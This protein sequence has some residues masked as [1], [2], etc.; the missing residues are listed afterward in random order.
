MIEN[1]PLW[2]MRTARLSLRVTFSSIQLPRSGMMRQL[3]K[4]RSPVPSI[5]HD[6]IDART[7]VELVDHDALGAVD[8]ELA[9]AEH[10]GH[11]AQVDL[12]LDRLLLGQPQPDLERP[13]VGQTK[14]A[15][16]VRLVARL[17]QLVADVLQAERLVVAFDR[18]NFAKHAFD[19][20][21]LALLPGHLVLQEGVVAAG[22]DLGQVGDRIGRALRT[23]AANF[24]GLDASLGGCRHRKSP[25]KKQGS[26][27]RLAGKA[28]AR[29][30]PHR[31]IGPGGNGKQARSYSVHAI[32]C[33]PASRRAMA[34]RLQVMGTCIR[35]TANKSSTRGKACLPET[36]SNQI[37]RGWNRQQPRPHCQRTDQAQS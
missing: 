28:T 12:F 36:V 30:A 4:R 23:E 29:G 17:A 1:L 11:V 13:A 24:L 3:C 8:D 18:E 19:A 25:L 26:P 5:S 20:L 16:L 6:E 31:G 2:S 7:A 14:L 9:A 27:R 34:K 35:P 37:L 15:A 22:L 21:V 33:P 10:D 32:H